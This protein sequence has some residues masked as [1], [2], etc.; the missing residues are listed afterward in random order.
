MCFLLIHIKFAQR[1]LF[2]F[3]IKAMKVNVNWKN[4]LLAPFGCRQIIPSHHSSFHN[5]PFNLLSLHTSNTP[6]KQN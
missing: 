6:I 3:N 1:F 2:I 4:N 5:Y